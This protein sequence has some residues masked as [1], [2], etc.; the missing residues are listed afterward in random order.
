MPDRVGTDAIVELPNGRYF[1]QIA[2]AKAISVLIALDIKDQISQHAG[3]DSTCAGCAHLPF[4]K[5]L[6]SSSK[7]MSTTV[8]C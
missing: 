5:I 8:A 1:H 4:V 3:K 7:P 2:W 6:R